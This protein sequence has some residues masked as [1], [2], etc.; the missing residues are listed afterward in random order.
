MAFGVLHAVGNRGH[1]SFACP[2]KTQ[3][4]VSSTHQ[5]S[6]DRRSAETN[7]LTEFGRATS[8][9]AHSWTHSIV[10]MAMKSSRASRRL[11]VD[12]FPFAFR[13]SSIRPRI[14]C[15]RVCG[16]GC[17][18]IQPSTA[19]RVS[20]GIRTKTGVA[21]VGGRP[22]PR[23]FPILLIAFMNKRYYK[24]PSRASAETLARL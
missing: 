9:R 20:G 7:S 4:M 15:G 12:H 18:L 10:V 14:P 3:G 5:C 13:P 23:F 22:R 24:I 11:H 19:L 8:I 1:A 16:S 2:L 17:F 6:L 21:P